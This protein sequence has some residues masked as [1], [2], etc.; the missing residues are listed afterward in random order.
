MW[1]QAV[2]EI[3]GTMETLFFSL[4]LQ[5]GILTGGTIIIRSGAAPVCGPPPSPPQVQTKSI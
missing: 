2:P 5:M 3:M 1:N 4:S